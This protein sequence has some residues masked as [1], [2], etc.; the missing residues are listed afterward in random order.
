MALNMTVR[1]G[2][3]QSF[4]ELIVD[5]VLYDGGK[6]EF[7]FMQPFSWN[8]LQRS[9]EIWSQMICFCYGIRNV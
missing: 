5:G 4:K 6:A 3:A 7:N 2:R 9:Y 1:T 8:Y